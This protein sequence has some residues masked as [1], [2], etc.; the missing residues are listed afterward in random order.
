MRRLECDF[1]LMYVLRRYAIPTWNIK[2]N[3]HSYF[4]VTCNYFGRRGIFVLIDWPRSSIHIF[5]TGLRSIHPKRWLT[6]AKKTNS[7]QNW[8]IKLGLI[9]AVESIGVDGIRW[10]RAQ[11]GASSQLLSRRHRESQNYWNPIGSRRNRLNWQRLI[12]TR[13]PI[14][15]DGIRWIGAQHGAS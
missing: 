15:T 11:H 4:E 1:E 13:K 5:P 12:C 6:G 2:A 14:G 9:F 3:I 7:T 10:K 8:L